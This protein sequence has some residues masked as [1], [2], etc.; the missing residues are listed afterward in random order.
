[1]P[2]AQKHRANEIRA[3]VFAQ[4][5]GLVF[6]LRLRPPFPQNVP[7]S[8]NV[9]R[10]VGQE[11]TDGDR[12]I[13]IHDRTTSFEVGMNFASPL[14]LADL[15]ALNSPPASQGRRGRNQNMLPPDYAGRGRKIPET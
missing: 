13:T 14:Q 6:S 7:G 8:E 12:K 9:W 1:V 3:P 15:R 2:A 5:T 10:L 11:D 4:R